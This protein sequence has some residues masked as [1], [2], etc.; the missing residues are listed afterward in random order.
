MENPNGDVPELDTERPSSEVGGE[1]GSPGDLEF[2]RTREIGTGS[3]ATQ[4]WTPAEDAV[5]EVHHDETGT[6][7]RSPNS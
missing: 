5:Q 6:G 2:D 7:R 4:T 1:G 3:E